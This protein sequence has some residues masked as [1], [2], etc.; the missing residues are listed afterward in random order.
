M[1]SRKPSYYE[2]VRVRPDECRGQKGPV[3]MVSSAFLD[4]GEPPNPDDGGRAA[5]PRA[6]VPA[7]KGIRLPGQGSCTLRAM[8]VRLSTVILAVGVEV[9][10]QPNG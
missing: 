8:A 2:I 10:T 4:E 7:G 6:R 5:E 1:A 3:V 9:P